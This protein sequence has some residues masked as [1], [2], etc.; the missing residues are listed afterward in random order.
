MMKLKFL[1]ISLER[2]R[3]S[4]GQDRQNYQLVHPDIHPTFPVLGVIYIGFAREV[5][6]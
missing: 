2:A 5:R 6:V 3:K 1:Y 4:D